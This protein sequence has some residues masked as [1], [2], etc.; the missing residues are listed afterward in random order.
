MNTAHAE[1]IQLKA[2]AATIAKEL[3]EHAKETARQ[4]LL[5]T[6]LDIS[7]IPLICERIGVI[8][9]DIS[10]IKDAMNTQSGDHEGRLRSVERNQWKMAGVVVVLTPLITMGLAALLGYF[11]K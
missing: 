4:M 7:K 1:A 6:N 9:D 8:K 5:N 3:V 10:G 11:I 2:E